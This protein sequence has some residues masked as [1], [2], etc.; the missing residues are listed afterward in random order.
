[1][2]FALVAV[3]LVLP[4]TVHVLAGDAHPS[5]PKVRKK[6]HR[7]PAPASPSGVGRTI[8]PTDAYY[9]GTRVDTIKEYTNELGQTVYSVAA[10][11]FDVSPP[12]VDMV[13]AAPREQAAGEGEDESPS[14]PMLPAWRIIRSDVPDPVVQPVVQAGDAE[15][16]SG[17][18]SAA[19]CRS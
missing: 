1:M 7:A 19:R 6:T 15:R 16:L 17:V 9:G 18:P 12:L 13:A 8:D 11:H 10:S 2:S 5:T 4:T 3:C 14:N